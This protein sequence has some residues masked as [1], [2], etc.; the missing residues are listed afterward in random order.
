MTVALQRIGDQQ[1]FIWCPI[2]RATV[3]LE[4][5]H[6]RF[7]RC[8]DDTTRRL[9][10]SLVGVRTTNGHEVQRDTTELSHVRVIVDTTTVLVVVDLWVTEHHSHVVGTSVRISVGVLKVSDDRLRSDQVHSRVVLV[11]QDAHVTIVVVHDYGVEGTSDVAAELTTVH[12]LGQISVEGVARLAVRQDEATNLSQVV[13]FVLTP[14]HI[15]VGRPT[16]SV[17]VDG[18]I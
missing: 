13:G 4:V 2:R 7:G 3:D 11:H 15:A 1:D 10:N 17:V 12:W 9:T 18:L 8:G 6:F 5:D 14:L 16:P